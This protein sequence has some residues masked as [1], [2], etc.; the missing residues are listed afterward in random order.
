MATKKAKKVT[1]SQARALVKK[2]NSDLI[3]ASFDAIENTAKTGE[4][5]QKLAS[6]LINLMKILMKI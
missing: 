4:K 5:W 6:K 2:I 1:I 3:D